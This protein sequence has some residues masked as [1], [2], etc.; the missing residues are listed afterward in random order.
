M[1]Q[2]IKKRLLDL[3][4][5]ERFDPADNGDCPGGHYFYFFPQQ[6]SEDQRIFRLPFNEFIIDLNELIRN[7]RLIF[8]KRYLI[9]SN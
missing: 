5:S 6:D 7:I 8:F 9:R 4:R 2:K 3:G 1:L